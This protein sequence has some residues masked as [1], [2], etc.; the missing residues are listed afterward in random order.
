MFAELI[1]LLLQALL[2]SLARPFAALLQHLLFDLPQRARACRLGR[3]GPPFRC[4]VFA[5]GGD[6]FT[7]LLWGQCQDAPGSHRP[8]VCP[9]TGISLWH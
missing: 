9:L 4:S 2:K 8:I 1:S 7:P 3:H 6:P 5:T